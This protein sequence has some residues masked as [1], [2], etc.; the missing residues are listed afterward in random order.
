MK[1]KSKIKHSMSDRTFNS[2]LMGFSIFWMII[3]LYPLIFV[4]SSSFSSGAAVSSGKVYLWPVDFS[5]TGYQLVFKN[6]LIWNG[7]LNSIFYSVAGTVLHLIG[8][9]CG[10]YPLSRRDYQGKKFIQVFLT[11]SMMF[12]GNLVSSYI[13]V[14]SLGLVDTRTYQIIS[15]MVTIGDMVVM[16]T[17][18]QSNIP[19]EL[20]ES[21]KM[22]GITDSQ[23]LHKIILPLSKAI[24]A[25]N[26][27]YGFVGRWNSFY[28]PMIYLRTREKYPLQLIANDILNKAKID[29]SQMMDSSLISQMGASVDAMRYALIVVTVLPVILIYPFVQKH[30]E[31]GVMVGSIKG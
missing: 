14:A 15:G 9:F 5:L 18:I 24:M 10:A 23:Y 28:H 25:V 30:F 21:A 19:Y 27:L 6:R 22:D 2:I 29:T 1:I 8:T 11:I 17:F 3:V 7:Y 12:S 4:L 20:L 13:L 31:K 16:R 26:C